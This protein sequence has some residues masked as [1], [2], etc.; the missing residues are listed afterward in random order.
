VTDR[1]FI[2]PVESTRKRCEREAMKLPTLFPLLSTHFHLFGEFP[3]RFAEY[4]I[5]EY[6]RSFV[7]S[8]P[9]ENAARPSLSRLSSVNRLS[10]ETFEAI[11]GTLGLL[12]RRR[13]VPFQ[14]FPRNRSVRSRIA[15]IFFS[16]LFVVSSVNNRA[17]RNH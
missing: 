13:S 12:Q 2:A 16:L 15:R 4:E 17:A 11:F 9:H 1:C 10:R 5:R 6:A 14:K 7:R 8:F 3:A